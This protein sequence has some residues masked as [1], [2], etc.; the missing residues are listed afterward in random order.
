MLNA[1]GQHPGPSAHLAVIRPTPMSHPSAERDRDAYPA[2]RRAFQRLLERL[3][4]RI[5][6]AKGKIIAL[7]PLQPKLQPIPSARRASAPLR[8]PQDHPHIIPSTREIERQ[9]PPEL[10]FVC[11]LRRPFEA[12]FGARKLGAIGKCPP[13]RLVSSFKILEPGPFLGGDCRTDR[14]ST[15]LN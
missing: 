3:P 6:V 5:A 4:G 13:R 8:H 2:A 11:R 14:K 9:L 15:R 1:Q 10:P 12:P 7:R